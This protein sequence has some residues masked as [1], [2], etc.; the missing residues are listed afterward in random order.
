MVYLTLADALA[1]DAVPTVQIIGAINDSA[2]NAAALGD[3]VTSADGIA[4]AVTVLLTSPP[5]VRSLP[6][7]R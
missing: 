5:L 7:P 2:A 1:A 6:T 3:T 4:P